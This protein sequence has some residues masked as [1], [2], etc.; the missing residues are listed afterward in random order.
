MPSKELPA[1]QKCLHDSALLRT[2][3]WSTV[4]C[5]FPNRPALA[6]TSFSQIPRRRQNSDDRFSPDAIPPDPGR[7]VVN[8]DGNQL[9]MRLEVSNYR[10]AAAF[11]AMIALMPPFARIARPALGL[12]HHFV[13]LAPPRAFEDPPSTAKKPRW[14]GRSTNGQREVPRRPPGLARPR[15][16]CGS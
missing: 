7:D 14:R 2:E 10:F 8:N 4:V 13:S 9:R 1:T 15:G 11:L 5:T 6:A 3:T 12:D 16:C